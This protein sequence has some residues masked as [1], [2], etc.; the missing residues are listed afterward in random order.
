MFPRLTSRFTTLQN[1]EPARAASK[2]DFSAEATG[3]S[4][5]RATA[6]E[7]CS[8][9]SCRHARRLDRM[10]P[11]TGRDELWVYGILLAGVGLW[12]LILWAVL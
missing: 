12:S 7:E 10:E 9:R 11:L 3:V 2:S 4:N 1:P 8:C 5:L 6:R